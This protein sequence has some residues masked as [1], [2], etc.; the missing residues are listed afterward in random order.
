MKRFRRA[1]GGLGI[2]GGLSRNESQR[3]YLIVRDSLGGRGG[4]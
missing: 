3:E 4:K 2:E 1:E